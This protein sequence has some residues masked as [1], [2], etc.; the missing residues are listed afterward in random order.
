MKIYI[1]RHGETNANISGIVDGWVDIPLNSKGRKLAQIT[2]KKMA[3]I[4]FDKVISSPLKRA[5][6]TAEII[7][8]Y[9]DAE[10][11]VIETE[12]RLKEMYWGEWECLSLSPANFNIPNKEN[13]NKFYTDPYD[14]VPAEDG[15]SIRDVVERTGE[16]YNELI[17]REDL[18][19]S[20]IL[21]ST[22][23]FAMRCLMQ[24]VYKDTTDF[25]HGGVP[26]NCAVQIIDVRDG[27]SHLIGDDVVYYDKSEAVNPFKP[28]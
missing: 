12:D 5:Y 15:E 1:I 10:S 4:K 7:L 25:W 21:L 23:G 2:A 22:H 28:V 19:D 16:F 9:N 18:K 27:V 11:P 6:E 13:F 3:D 20:T 24:S 8:K 17:H 14:F 26:D